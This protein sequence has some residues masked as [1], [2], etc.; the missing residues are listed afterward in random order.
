MSHPAYH[1][2]P[3]KAI[4][5]LLMLEAIRYFV[6]QHKLDG[7]TYYSLGGPL[8]EDFQVLHNAMPGMRLVSIEEL[9][10][11]LKRQKFHQ[12]CGSIKLVES[13]F[14][15]F[16]AAEDFSQSKNIVWMDFTGL[17]Y[18]DIDQ[19][20][21]LLPKLPC[22]SIVKITLRCDP[23]IVGRGKLP[24]QEAFRE[25]FS[26]VWPGG[27]TI[28]GIGSHKD[29]SA[30]LLA[31]MRV[32]STRALAATTNCFMPISSFYYDDGTKMFTFAGMVVSRPQLADYQEKIS[33]WAFANT[34]WKRKPD[35]IDVPT[36][37]AKERLHLQSVF[38]IKTKIAGTLRKRLGYHLDENRAKSNKFLEQYAIFYRFYPSFIRAANF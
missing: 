32:A 16:L 36:V 14:K 21:G 3:N 30:F 33:G 28:A 34:D 9:P 19:F 17:K 8:L 13:D 22:E 10:Q 25:A 7:Y 5:R 24:E 1:L 4:D 11:T 37:S 6:P 31:M 29:Y 15:S 26:G 27:W 35:N 2:R 23:G 20:M 38:P 12:P 18:D